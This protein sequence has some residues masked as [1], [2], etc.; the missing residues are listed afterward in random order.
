MGYAPDGEINMENLNN[1]ASET[2][3][4]ALESTNVWNKSTDD[5]DHVAK[6]VAVIGTMARDQYLA[7]RSI[8]RA[9]YRELSRE[10]RATKPQRKGGNSQAVD[11]VTELRGQAR[12]YMTVRHAL[13]ACARAH[14]EAT[15]IKAA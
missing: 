2:L 4:K 8:W 10:S 14:A 5:A 6:V 13:K 7:L 12:R 15:R 11:R 3:A 9:Q 1:F